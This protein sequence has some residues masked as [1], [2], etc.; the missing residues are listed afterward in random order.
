M[1]KVLESQAEAQAQERALWQ[2]EREAWERR[3]ARLLDTIDHLA[4]RVAG[5]GPVADSPPGQPR[6]PAT[7]PPAAM[8]PPP[9]KDPA[10]QDPP[11]DPPAP[12]ERGVLGGR[13]VY[14]IL[15]VVEEVNR[16]F[17]SE[18]PAA[19]GGQSPEGIAP[20]KAEKKGGETLP[21]ESAPSDGAATAAAA[22]EGAAGSDAGLG[23]VDRSKPKVLKYGDNDIFWVNQLQAALLREG[24]YCGEEEMEEWYFGEHTRTALLTFQ[25]MEKIPETGVCDTDT[26]VRLLGPGLELVKAEEMPLEVQEAAA[27]EDRAGEDPK[28]DGT[29]VKNLFA[30][31]DEKPSSGDGAPKAGGDSPGAAQLPPEG[32]VEQRAEWPVLRL[33]DSGPTVHRLQAALTK[34]GFDCG[35]DEMR[36]WM[37]GDATQVALMTFQA[38]SGIPETGVVDRETWLK[39]LGNPKARP[40]DIQGLKTDDSFD[41]D[42]TEEGPSAGQANRVWLIG[43]QRWSRPM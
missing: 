8:D 10:A 7:A 24:L 30:F 13:G 29:D 4:A 9:A 12:G 1:Q 3:E 28:T 39:L 31:L 25:A 43:E 11:G 16:R 42:L 40:E 34:S 15:D 41:E 26:W 38:C 6:S 37:F 23:E 18:R 2:R 21:E 22:A 5:A 32:G 35:E 19:E 36:W 33:D 17:R 27:E 20:G 14:D